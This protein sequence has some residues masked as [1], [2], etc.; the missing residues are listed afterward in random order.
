[1]SFVMQLILN[2][3]ESAVLRSLADQLKISPAQLMRNALKSYQIKIAS[4][5]DTEIIDKDTH[6]AP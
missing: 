5:L 6:D 4:E 3:F 2:D 1:M